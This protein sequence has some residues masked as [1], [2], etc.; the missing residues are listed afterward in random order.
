MIDV[1]F[2]YGVSFLLILLFIPLVINLS[3]RFGLY[4]ELDA[5][6][7][8]HGKYIS[9]LGGV[10]IFCAFICSAVVFLKTTVDDI[11]FL[12]FAGYI[13][14]FLG[15][16]DDLYGICP[17]KKC[18]VQLIIAMVLSLV[19]SYHLTSTY[20]ASGMYGEVYWDSFFSIAIII[21]TCNS[22]NLID[23]ID[24]LA[25]SIGLMVNV[26]LGSFLFVLGAME[27][28]IIGFAMAGAISG[29]LIFNYKPAKIFMGD[30]GA[31]FIGLI[32]VCLAIKFI[33]LSV[34]NPQIGCPAPAIVVA[35]LIVPVFDSFRVLM[36]RILKGISPFKGDRRHIH[37]CLKELGLNDGQVVMVLN[38]FS[39]C[40]L[41]LVF[42]FHKVGN[43]GL[44]LIQVVLSF[45]FYLLIRYRRSLN[46]FK[47]P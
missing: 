32:S 2:A 43:F 46:G 7:K 34:I 3:H 28:A 45:L 31:M 38:F 29:F 39:I 17:L 27:L 10:G 30:A 5:Y 16:I 19:G 23:G 8:D 44:I 25:G 6:R 12:L 18:L 41:I 4:D 37:H 36:M 20:V 1:L 47:N 22:F 11:Y 21:F 42:V 24:G 40:M 13:V 15:L 35:A 9:R 33:E 26:V 14:F